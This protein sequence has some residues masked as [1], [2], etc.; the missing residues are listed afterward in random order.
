MFFL[1]EF[2]DCIDMELEIMNVL[3]F[4]DLDFKFYFLNSI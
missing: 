1:F 3:V 4:Y 2:L